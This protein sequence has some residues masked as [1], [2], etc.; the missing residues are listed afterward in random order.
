MPG[1]PY[2]QAGLDL[3]TATNMLMPKDTW[4]WQA[5]RK[6]PATKGL[7][8]ACMAADFPK[9]FWLVSCAAGVIKA[10]AEV[11]GRGGLAFSIQEFSH[12]I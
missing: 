10:K 11:S 2:R 12:V 3:R 5:W 9:L 7:V 8:H 1:P 6:R 4:R